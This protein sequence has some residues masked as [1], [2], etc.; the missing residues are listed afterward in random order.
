MRK[1]ID[2]LTNQMKQLIIVIAFLIPIS[3]L[4][5]QE[6]GGLEVG[7]KENSVVKLSGGLTLSSGF[8]NSITGNIL[9]TSPFNYS[10]GG[11]LQ[12][13]IASIDIP[14]SLV[15]RDHSLGLSKPFFY[16]GASPT[17]GKTKLHL[18]FR[19]L[20]FSKYT[21]GGAT[22]FGVGAETSLGKLR[23]GGMYGSFQNPFAQRD[24]IVYGAIQLPTFDRKG[25]SLKLGYGTDRNHFD[26]IYLKIGDDYIPSESEQSFDFKPKENLV[27][28]AVGRFN[29]GKNI[30]FRLDAAISGLTNDLSFDLIEIEDEFINDIR[31]IFEINP[32][33]NLFYAGESELRLNF[34]RIRPFVKYRRISP[35]YQSLGINYLT[36]DTEDWT[37]GFQG[38]LW[39]RKVRINTQVGIQ[40]NNLFNHKTSGSHRIVSTVNLSYRDKGPFRM[41]V[42]YNNYDISIEPTVQEVNDTFQFARVMNQL[43]ISPSYIIKGEGLHHNISISAMNQSL[44]TDL[45]SI[46]QQST[47]CYLRAAYNI[48][49][50]NQQ[51]NTGLSVDFNRNGNLAFVRDRYGVSMNVSKPFFRKKVSTG[52]TTSFFKNLINGKNDGSM[53]RVALNGS[54]RVNKKNSLMA[55]LYYV[56]RQSIIY[57][58][59]ADIQ[60]R[61]SYTLNF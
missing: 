8:Y 3:S 34:K 52:L 11:N 58:S 10:V 36:P 16:L 9:R 46:N 23:V 37:I 18:G 51:L 47:N 60:A 40:R 33:T 6:A 50:V 26:I 45:S 19:N 61:T 4:S 35:Y 2:P 43:R 12:L 28:G 59:T 42:Q 39:K 13:K 53:I 15:Y 20:R 7:K 17:F 25:F 21:L 31:N 24:T 22:F 48:S 30:S 14:L 41:N 56:N 44:S 29:L 55:S 27:I 57:N 38:V 5:A 49:H 1:I 32:T 54:Y